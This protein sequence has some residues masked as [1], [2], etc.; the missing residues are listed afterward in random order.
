VAGAKA[1][2]SS[3]ASR[4]ASGAAP[5]ASRPVARAYATRAELRACMNDEDT[6]RDRSRKLEEAHA[7]HEKAISELEAEN[8]KIVEVQG[9]LDHESQTAVTAFNLLVGQHNARA[10]ELNREATEMSAQSE[11]FNADS[12]ALNKR[13][14]SLV[15][16]IDDMDAVMKERKAAAK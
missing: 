1:A 15:Y 4:A 16:R 2:A 13:C 9:Q 3:P 10:N 6:L 5:A 11:A 7:A 14:A 12:L 8:T